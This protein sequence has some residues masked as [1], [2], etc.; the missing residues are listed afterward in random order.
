M[1][2]VGIVDQDVRQGD[3]E[4]YL[5]RRVTARR[6]AELTRTMGAL[7]DGE[8]LRNAIG[9][10]IKGPLYQNPIESY[11]N[12]GLRLPLL[13]FVSVG[14]SDEIWTALQLPVEVNGDRNASPAVAMSRI[15]I[16]K[17]IFD[18]RIRRFEV[19]SKG[20]IE[21]RRSDPLGNFFN[22]NLIMEPSGIMS[23]ETNEN[24]GL[25]VLANPAAQV[26]RR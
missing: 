7:K 3:L 8:P 4:E 5:G 10:R 16:A 11:H 17:G 19:G 22:V 15:D 1:S 24:T 26:L 21:F 20:N 2:E 14:G 13:G 12:F 18:P 9:L 23:L 25:Y 6:I